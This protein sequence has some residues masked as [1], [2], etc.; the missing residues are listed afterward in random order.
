MRQEKKASG[1][2]GAKG[3]LFELDGAGVSPKTVDSLLLLNLATSFFRLVVKLAE[4]ERT[5]LT[6]RGLRVVDKCVAVAVDPSDGRSA[7]VYSVRAKRIVSGIETA[8]TGCV[9]IARDI[10]Y[11]IRSLA[12]GTKATIRCDGK[13]QPLVAPAIEAPQSP[14]ETLELRAVPLRVGGKNLTVELFSESELDT[15]IVKAGQQKPIALKNA[16]AL[17]ASLQKEVDVALI[18]LRGAD[19]KI[20]DGYITDVFEV[21]DGDPLEIWQKWFSVECQQIEDAEDV[22]IAIGRYN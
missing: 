16:R 3:L 10:Q 19:G 14:W 17:G 12:K 7:Q 6:L 18:A 2:K 21:Q 1:K 22:G 20:S 5:G 9:D 13:P 8:P 15:F 11:G 4:N